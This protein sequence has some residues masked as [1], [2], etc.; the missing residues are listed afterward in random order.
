MGAERGHS[1]RKGSLSEEKDAC[2]EAIRCG[3]GESRTEMDSME[4]PLFLSAVGT[5]PPI[6]YILRPMQRARACT[7]DQAR[8]HSRRVYCVAHHRRH[9]PIRAWH[10]C[11]WNLKPGRVRSAASPLGT[12]LLNR[13]RSGSPPRMTVPPPDPHQT[14]L[15]CCMGD[16]DGE[17][18][19]KHSMHDATG[20]CTVLL[21]A[22]VGDRGA[23][24]W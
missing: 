13:R 5:R 7:H 23:A 2:F 9:G 19:P 17:R 6:L 16:V 20:V 3:R 18:I 4:V 8:N 21:V 11:D 22:G 12:A 14:W 24:G 10:S 15:A 1:V